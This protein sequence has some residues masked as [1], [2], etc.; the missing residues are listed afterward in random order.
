M[1]FP[2]CTSEKKRLIIYSRLSVIDIHETKSGAS[3][4]F[5][6]VSEQVSDGRNISLL[7]SFRNN[8]DTNQDIFL[9]LNSESNR[10]SRF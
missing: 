4:L 9:C 8:F 2:L 10:A 7:N 1:I 6:Q 3:A 5:M